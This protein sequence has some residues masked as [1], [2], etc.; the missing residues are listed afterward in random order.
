V[1]P[2]EVALSY[3]YNRWANARMFGSVAALSAADLT[4]PLG[5]SFGS[6][7]D[8]L[9]HLLWAEKLWLGRWRQDP[10]PVVYRP[11]EFSSLDAITAYW[12]DF[13]SDQTAFVRS[14]SPAALAATIS[15]VNQ[16][17]ER[18]AYPLGRMMQHVVNH[19]TY[20]RGQVA[21]SLRSLGVAPAPT[22]FLEYFDEGLAAGA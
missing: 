9:A 7:R 3:A 17:G 19:S 13:E 2:E 6:V 14:V 10:V 8:T 15:Y 11:D 5:G 21:N 20:H 16:Q 18:W 1:D 12:R 4:R 22:D